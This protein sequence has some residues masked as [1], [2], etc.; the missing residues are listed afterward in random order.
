MLYRH[1]ASAYTIDGG[2]IESREG[3]IA[4]KV[5]SIRVVDVRNINVKQSILN[6]LLGIGA[7]EFS[8]AAAT[9]AEV[10]FNDIANPMRVKEKVQ[11][12]L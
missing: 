5:N 12:M 11:A 2:N 1:F 4:R 7:I 3:I 10:V 6:R 9:E 8:S